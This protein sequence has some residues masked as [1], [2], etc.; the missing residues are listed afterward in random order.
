MIFNFNKKIFFAL[1]LSFLLISTAHGENI[2]SDKKY[3]AYF[4]EGSGSVDLFLICPTVD[5][6]DEYNMSL[7]DNF[8]MGNFLGALNMERGIYEENT[9][10]YAPYY[11]Q[12]A[13]KAYNLSEELRTPFFDIAYGDIKEAFSYYL[14]HENKNRP[15]ILAGFSQGAEMCYKILEDFFK[16][17]ELN[18]RL[19][20]VYA[21]G[22]RLE[23]EFVKK[24]P[25]IKPA[26]SEND[27]GVVITFDC[28]DPEI[29]SSS[30]NPEDMQVFAI[31]PLNWKTDGT[32]AEKNLNLG[33]CFTD[34]SGEIKS[35]I[36]NF[37]GCYIDTERGVLKVP[38][39]ISADYPPVV[40]NLPLG[41]YH[42]YDYLFF[43]R[44]LQENVKTRIKNF[45]DGR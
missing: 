29:H 23:K 26:Q 7:S 11:R 43:Y 2:Y 41:A 14:E 10:M 38:G 35:E 19:V 45:Y 25:H 17:E 24:N 18:S 34:Y 13:I 16:D 33:A 44:N 3:W 21:I 1:L 30:I 37:C 36:K 15:I 8:T 39:L 6:N 12:M 42:V 22:W 5:V 28:E 4:S 32:P 40:S 27:V 31:N 9:R 20:A